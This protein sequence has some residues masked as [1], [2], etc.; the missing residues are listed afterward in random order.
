MDFFT[1]S[2]NPEQ[3]AGRLGSL[4]QPLQLRQV[5]ALANER[6]DTVSW[7]WGDPDRSIKKIGIVGGA[8]DSEWREARNAGADLLLTGEVKQHVAL[9]AAEQRF[10]MIASGHYA[11]EQP[12]CAT[13]RDRLAVEAPDVEWLLY[14]PPKGF[15]GRPL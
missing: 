4:A 5:V 6:L 1:L 3:S 12:G 2:P 9:E 7:A 13:L 10:S 14:V 8:A 15:S 11:T